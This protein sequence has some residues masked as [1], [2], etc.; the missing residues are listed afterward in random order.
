[1]TPAAPSSFRK[2]F[3][4]GGTGFIGRHLLH[5]LLDRG[6]P[7]VALARDPKT[8]DSLLSPEKDR[9]TIVRG[10]DASLDSYRDA[11]LA[12]DAVCHIAAFIPPDFRDPAHAERCMEVNALWTLQLALLA[13]AK[14]GIRFVYLSSGAC[15]TPSTEPVD[16]DSPLFPAARA[17]YYL[18]SKLAGELYVEQM[19][20]A[21]KLGSVI[22]R[23]GSVY[24]HGSP[25]KGMISH[26]VARARQGET[27]RVL[28]GGNASSDLT[29]VSDIAKLCAAALLQGEP[30]IYNAGTGT[31]TTAL[32]A[33]RTVAE[34]F[35][36]RAPRIEVTPGEPAF[37]SFP[38]LSMKKSSAAFDHQPLTLRQG[39]E[40]DKR[41][42][43]SGGA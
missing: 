20:H 27:L 12:C 19:R 13:A 26:F 42:L 21:R 2:V 30:G 1:M 28:N 6:S 14:P 3:L 39:L 15:Y 40:L 18:A 22:L 41:M 43:E 8:F 11:V 34:I 25:S 35:H 33:A 32:E 38:A 10:D 37:A 16:E 17:T 7:V 24:G 5:T 31:A 23:V 9:L 4:T 36:E 29:H